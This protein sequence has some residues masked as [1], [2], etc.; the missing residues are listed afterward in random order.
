MGGTLGT[1]GSPVRVALFGSVVGLAVACGGGGDGGGVGPAATNSPDASAPNPDGT[2]PDGGALPPGTLL[3]DGGRVPD[4]P[5]KPA[6]DGGKVT[7]DGATPPISTTCVDGQ[8]GGGGPNGGPADLFPCDS[9]WY[10]DVT[11]SPVAPQSDAILAAIGAFGTGAFRIDFS[12]VFMHADAATPRHTFTID[13]TADSDTD[14]VPVPVGG[15]LEE[16]DGYTC[17]GGGDCHLVVVDD[18]KKQLFEMWSVQNASGP[19]TAAQ[20][21][22]WDLTKHY[23]PEGRGIG[24]TSADAAGLAILPGMIGVRETRAGLIRHA[25]RFILPNAKIRKGPSYVAPATL[26][27]STTSSAGGPPYG[28]RLRLKKTFDE[29]KVKSTGGKAIVTALKTY[30]MLLADGGNYALTAENERLEL[31]KDP[32]MTWAGVLGGNDLTSILPTDFEVVDF[33]ALKTGDD[34]TLK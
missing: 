10:K 20:E 26:G 25:L 32:T 14:P 21:T 23:G 19:Y 6:S 17:T 11:A 33:S 5:P 30:G 29:T 13:D 7:D 15:T 24:C 27:T 9:P 31:A 4:P 22:V 28:S 34:C 16:E 3:P 8:Q 18:S 12:F 2:L 1:F